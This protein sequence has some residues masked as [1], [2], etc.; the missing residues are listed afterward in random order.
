MHPAAVAAAAAALFI[1]L[2]KLMRAKR[3]CHGVLNI[4][5]DVFRV[6]WIAFLFR[7][8]VCSAN[9]NI[10]C[11]KQLIPDSHVK[12][13]FLRLLFAFRPT[14]LIDP[15]I[16]FSRLLYSSVSCATFLLSCNPDCMCLN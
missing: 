9:G 7:F 4:A 11:G 15:L 5:H 1:E 16:Y 2:E 3:I 13:R 14:D 10:D 12:E 8:T 6:L